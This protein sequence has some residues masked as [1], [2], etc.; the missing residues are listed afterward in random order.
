MLPG[1]NWRRTTGLSEPRPG[2]S[3]ITSRKRTDAGR[4][5]GHGARPR[6]RAGGES[7]KHVW[8]EGKALLVTPPSAVR[9]SGNRRFADSAVLPRRW[10]RIVTA[11]GGWKLLGPG[12]QSATTPIGAGARRSRQL[13]CILYSLW[14]WALKTGQQP[15][16]LVAAVGGVLI[17]SRAKRCGSIPTIASW[18]AF[19]ERPACD[20][21]KRLLSPKGTLRL[22]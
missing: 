4:P 15:P 11:A 1:R 21:L 14:N 8:S 6:R 22:M 10:R 13:R 20:S 5:S 17:G 2:S 12:G 16:V 18:E 19:L 3:T 7:R 9:I